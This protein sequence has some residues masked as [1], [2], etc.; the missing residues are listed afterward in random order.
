MRYKRQIIAVLGV[1][2]TLVA[3]G[4][5]STNDT[6]ELG[7]PELGREIFEDRD[8]VRC[9]ECHTLD[10]SILVGPSLQ[11]VSE[12]AGDRV[13]ELIAVEYLRQSILDPSAYIVEGFDDK[14]ETFELV[15]SE[16]LDNL[17]LSMLTQEEL[18]DL[19]AFLL[20]Q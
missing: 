4:G 10:G 16:T 19:V 12:R 11:G 13:P 15:Q 2:I 20:T 7:N 8:R 5:G 3:C 17:V 6:L 9:V 14:M 1:A 18:S